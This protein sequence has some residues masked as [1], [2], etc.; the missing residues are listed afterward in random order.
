[1]IPIPNS[2][3]GEEATAALLAKAD[4][5]EQTLR[6]AGGRAPEAFSLR[7]LFSTSFPVGQKPFL[8]EAFFYLLPRGRCLCLGWGSCLGHA[9]GMPGT[10]LDW[11]AA[12]NAAAAGGEL[13]GGSTLPAGRSGGEAEK[14]VERQA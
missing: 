9:W 7:S 10:R 1:M 11:T 8:S 5:I 6:A 3:L 14:A 2:K 12:A 4:E 13:G